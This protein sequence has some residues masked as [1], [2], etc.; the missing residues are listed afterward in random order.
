M[1]IKAGSQ[2]SQAVGN[3]SGIFSFDPNAREESSTDLKIALIL[4]VIILLWEIVLIFHKHHF[5]NLLIMLFVLAIYFLNYFDRNYIKFILIGL[6]SSVLLDILWLIVMAKVK[7][8]FY[9]LA[10][11]GIC[12]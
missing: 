1:P 9:F 12:R 5:F 7:N 6:G 8:W 11:L 4:S 10:F 2:P 3:D